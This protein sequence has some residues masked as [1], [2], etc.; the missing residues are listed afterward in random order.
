MTTTPFPLDGTAPCEASSSGEGSL[1]IRFWILSE[2]FCFSAVST[3]GCSFSHPITYVTCPAD[4]SLLASLKVVQ[5]QISPISI[6]FHCHLPFMNSP[7]VCS[8]MGILITET[9]LPIKQKSNFLDASHWRWA[10]VTVHKPCLF[11]FKPP[12]AVWKYANKMFSLLEWFSKE[13]SLK[14]FFLFLKAPEYSLVI[15][16]LCWL[17]AD[18]T[19]IH[20]SKKKESPLF[21]GSLMWWLCR[22]FSQPHHDRRPIQSYSFKNCPFKILPYSFSF[23]YFLPDK[24]STVFILLHVITA[25]S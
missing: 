21:G 10:A 24:Y 3:L 1:K 20:S 18:W 15:C 6:L 22:A 11:P 2:A 17:N 7:K 12:D 23:C 4:C 13:P 14:I 5:T 8:P 19:W 16:R 25:L 9:A